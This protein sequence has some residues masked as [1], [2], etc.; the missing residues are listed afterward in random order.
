MVFPPREP[1]RSRRSRPAFSL[2]E[3]LVVIAIISLL[4]AIVLPALARARDAANTTR[5]L[6]HLSQIGR[7]IHA[8]AMAYDGTMPI[9]W[10]R[11]PI[12]VTLPADVQFDWTVLVA[13][14]ISTAEVPDSGPRPH[15]ARANRVF[16]C[17]N[18]GLDGGFVHYS[19]HPVLM[20][21][22]SDG[23]FHEPYNLERLIR[24]AA[25]IT[26]TDGSQDPDP[27][28]NPGTDDEPNAHATLWRLDGQRFLTQ[29]WHDPADTDLDEP[30]DPGPNVDA[31]A[32]AGHIRFRQHD[33]TAANVLYGDGHAATRRP[34]QITRAAIR[35]D[36]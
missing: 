16:R 11:Q 12:D 17:P 34:E 1:A 15:P 6:A 36:R 14:Y 35:P 32:G 4:V 29:R 33:E 5:G 23:R 26:L 21:D 3:L 22:L 28:G 2:I 31:P 18:A 7:A 10:Y 9:G 19:A 25:V 20:P 13:D 8:Y 30:I 24:A 27:D